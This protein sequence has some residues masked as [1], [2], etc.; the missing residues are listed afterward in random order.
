MA[1]SERIKLQGRKAEL[2]QKLDELETRAENHMITIRSLI[3]PL[4]V[5]TFTDLEVKRAEQA[6]ISLKVLVKK[7]RDKK[8][9]LKEVKEALGEDG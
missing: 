1:N 6:M 5:D 9:K 8:K 3:D 2:K 4:A 7:A